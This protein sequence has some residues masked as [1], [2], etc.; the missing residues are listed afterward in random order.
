MPFTVEMAPQV[1]PFEAAN[2][3]EACLFAVF[4]VGPFGKG[5]HGRLGQQGLA[6]AQGRDA[7]ER[8]HE[9]GLEAG[10]VAH[11]QARELGEQGHAQA[12]AQA[13]QAAD[14]APTPVDTA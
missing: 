4:R 5:A 3:G 7:A 2:I 8:E 10:D 6:G 1:L 13:Q 12:L 9:Q 11:Q 14:L